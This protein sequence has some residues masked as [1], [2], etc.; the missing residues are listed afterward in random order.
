M[1]VYGAKRREVLQ[2]VL[3][4][5]G[6]QHRDYL[7][8]RTPRLRGSRDVYE[9]LSD[10]LTHNQYAAAPATSVRNAKAM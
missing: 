9:R 8:L 7:Q 4:R 6:Q 2:H 3:S 1:L 5:L 10:I